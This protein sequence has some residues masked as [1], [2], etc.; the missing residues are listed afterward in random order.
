MIKVIVC[1]PGKQARVED[2]D[3]SLK[4]MQKIVGGYIEAFY[5]FMDNVCIVCNDEGKIS[6]MEPNRAVFTESGELVDVVFGTFFIC[7][8]DN[9]NEDFGSLSDKQIEKYL[10]IFKNPR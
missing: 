2:I 3:E 1:E 9:D 7:G 4:S 6:G 5:P 10:E 8:L